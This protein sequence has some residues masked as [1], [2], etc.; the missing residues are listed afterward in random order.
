MIIK[1]NLCYKQRLVGGT[2]ERLTVSEVICVEAV[3]S[4]S[5]V[6]ELCAGIRL[7]VSEVPGFLIQDY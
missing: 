6:P 2:A 1:I 3:V 4:L 5:E 7:Y